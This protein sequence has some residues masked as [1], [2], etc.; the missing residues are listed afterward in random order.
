VEADEWRVEV[1][2]EE[3]HHGLS[4]G[5]R[6]RAHD[7]DDEARRRL[8]GRVIVTKDGP[9]VFLYAASEEQAH[10]AER[11]ARE[12]VEA[13]G[14]R[15]RVTVTRWHPDEEA[16]KDTSIPLPGTDAERAAER[17]LREQ[18]EEREAAVEGSYEWEVRVDLPG[19][20]EAAELEQELRDEGLDVHRLWRY[21]S[22]GAATEERAN[23]LAARLRDSLPAAADVR[24][25]ANP[26][27]LPTG[28]RFAFFGPWR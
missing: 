16:W 2:L 17:A 8:G 25:E 13:E 3:E 11:V 12:L 1:E 14:R 22:V 27:E 18:A 9:H 10:E 7:L 26:E 23:E 5:E 21:L 24:V 15:A 6:L 28:A 19:R 4:L 20:S